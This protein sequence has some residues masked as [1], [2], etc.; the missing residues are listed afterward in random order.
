LLSN[1]DNLY[2]KVL[3]E[4]NPQPYLISMVSIPYVFAVSNQVYYANGGGLFIDGDGFFASKRILSNP[5]NIVMNSGSIYY[6]P[7][8]VMGPHPIHRVTMNG[9]GDTIT[10]ED[11]VK[12]FSISGN[13]FFYILGS[14][15]T[16]NISA[17]KIGDRGTG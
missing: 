16:A 13:K 9:T 15:S 3:S 2:K 1:V 8:S 5:K 17:S 14:R 6:Q 11:D 10:L 12:S 4:E 7:A